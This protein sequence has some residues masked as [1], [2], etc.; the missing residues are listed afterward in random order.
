M[1]SQIPVFVWH[2]RSFFCFFWHK[3]NSIIVQSQSLISPL[4][5]TKWIK[6]CK[7]QNMSLIL[8]GTNCLILYADAARLEIVGSHPPPNNKSILNPQ[9]GHCW[10]WCRIIQGT[11]QDTLT[12]L[13]HTVYWVL[14]NEETYFGRPLMQIA[15]SLVMKPAS[16]VSMQTASSASANTFSSAFLSSF[17]LWSK[18][19]VHAKMEATVHKHPV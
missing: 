1:F 15:K 2:F 14:H 12:V 9:Q 4:L 10:T 11:K 7:H 18:P 19:R 6:E 13:W 17:A 16:M 8:R 3:S 5:T